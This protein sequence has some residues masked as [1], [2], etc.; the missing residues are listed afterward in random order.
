MCD[1]SPDFFVTS[2][3]PWRAAALICPQLCTAELLFA[4]DEVAIRNRDCADDFRN[5]SQYP[6]A[7]CQMADFRNQP[8]MPFQLKLPLSNQPAS[9]LISENAGWLAAAVSQRSSGGRIPS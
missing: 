5:Q 8:S 2:T 1:R 9:Q 6:T 3:L 7:N 4:A